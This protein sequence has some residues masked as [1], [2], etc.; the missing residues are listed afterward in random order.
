MSQECAPETCLD[1][2]ACQKTIEVKIEPHSNSSRDLLLQPF[3]S[4]ISIQITIMYPSNKYLDL[5]SL[6][7]SSIP[8]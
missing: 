5:L 3:F 8:L 4:N 7:T 6:A 2:E 1:M